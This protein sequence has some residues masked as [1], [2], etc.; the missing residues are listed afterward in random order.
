MQY[1]RRGV[2]MHTL[3]VT[4]FY[5]QYYRDVECRLDSEAVKSYTSIRST[6]AILLVRYGAWVVTLLRYV[7][8]ASSSPMLVFNIPTMDR[9]STRK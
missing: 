3:I 8:L 6:A 1:L 5:C 4:F 7:G 2:N 9:I